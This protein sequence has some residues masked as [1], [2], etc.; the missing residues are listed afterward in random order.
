MTTASVGFIGAGRLAE[1]V[2]RHVVQHVTPQRKFCYDKQRLV[3]TLLASDPCAAR[4]R[5]FARLGFTTTDANQD[6]LADCDVVFL[7]TDARAALAAHA[8]NARTLYVSLMGDLPTRAVEKLLCPGAKVIRLMPQSDLAKQGL[9][10]GVLPLRSWATVRGAHASGCD[11]KH[12]MRLAGIEQGIEVDEASTTWSFMHRS[13]VERELGHKSGRTYDVGATMGGPAAALSK[14]AVHTLGSRGGCTRYSRARTDAGAAEF[15]DTY[16]VVREL[17]ASKFSRV[18]EVTHRET[19]QQFAVKIVRD[20]D[21]A[22]EGREMLVAEVGA[23]NRLAHPHIISHHGLYKEAGT[24]LLVLEYCNYGSVGGLMDELKV[25]PEHVAK[26]ILKQTLAALAYCHE[27]GQVHRDVKAENVLLCASED[28]VL[29]VK[30]ADFGLSE[31]LQHGSRHLQTMCGTPQ[32]LSPELVS[33]RRHG[34]PADIWGAGI[35][36][37]M[38]LSGLVPFHEARNDTELFK[39][40]SL[41][42]VWYDQPQ[43]ADVSPAAKDFVQRMLEVSVES[44]CTAAELLQHDWLRDA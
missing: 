34:A 28:G 39:L 14:R 17:A 42:A 22:P 35:L 10:R 18:N 8:T 12:V 21:S 20:D 1:R 40:I 37:Y 5:V 27:M 16:A 23:L 19:G 43:W 36:A 29:T 11:L 30:L 32:Y 9:P 31:E 41:G 4:R 13:G 3:S 2:A 7:G 33:G 38:M 6:V 24:Y 15:N 44:R 25:V 26:R